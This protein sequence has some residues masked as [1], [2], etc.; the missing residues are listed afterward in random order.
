MG[1]AGSAASG[2]FTGRNSRM[3]RRRRAK[4]TWFPVIGTAGPSETDDDFSQL[5][6]TVNIAPDGATAVAINPLIPDVPM[7][8]DTID[9]GAPG[10]LVQALGQEYVVKRIVGKCFLGVQTPADD[11]PTTI[12]PKSFLIGVGIFVARANDADSGGG[13]NQP[14]GSATL[15]ERQDNYSPLSVDP[16]RE[17]WMFRRV[18]ILN[19]GRSADGFVGGQQFFNAGNI[20]NASDNRQFAS[21]LD[22]PHFDVKSARRVRTDERLWLVLAARTLDQEFQVGGFPKPNQI[23]PEAVGMVFDY[24]VLGALRKAQNRSNF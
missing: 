21:A 16:I 15:D 17:P 11:P 6:A 1:V 5:I 23:A 7:E 12:F 13:A 20:G 22:G 19:S 8:G 4:Y 3:R 14:I 10:Q 2:G 18:W 9:A 24:R